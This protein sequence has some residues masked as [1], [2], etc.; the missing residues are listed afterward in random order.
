MCKELG[1]GTAAEFLE[2]LCQFA[3]N[4][5]LPVGHYLNARFERF[6]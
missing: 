1:G 2:L 5:K 4:A 3:C 6:D